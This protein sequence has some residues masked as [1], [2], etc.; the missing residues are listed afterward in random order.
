MKRWIVK[1]GATSVDDLV[2]QEVLL[3]EPGAGEVR[4]KVHAASLNARD[5]LLVNATFAPVGADFIALSDGAGEIDAI[6][7][8]VDG[9]SI[10]DRVTGSYF[11]GWVDGPPAPGQGWGLGSEGQDGMLAQCVVLPAGRVT[12]MPKTLSFAEAACLPCA[13]LTAWTALNGDRPYRNRIGNGDKVLVTGTGAVALFSLLLAK[14]SGAEVVVTTSDAA[15]VDRLL[16]LGAS[17]TVNYRTTPAWGEVAAQ[18]TGGFDR[19]VNAAGGSALD[20]SLAALAPGGEIAFMGLFD[21]AET[22]PDFVVLMMK[23]ASIRGTSVGSA[24]AHRDM[25]EFIDAHGIKPVIAETFALDDAKAAYRAAAS[26]ERFGKVVID[27]AG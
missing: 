19:V 14:A 15:K 20:Q 23:G 4:V 9:W 10:G 25:V 8:D 3:P 5:E 26:G 6:G 17:D 2:L 13:A 18:R 11:P 1:A 7:P 12:P 24:L 21:R 16:A 22:P 27:V